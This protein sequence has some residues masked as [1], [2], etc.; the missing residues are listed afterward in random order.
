MAETVTPKSGGS[1]YMTSFFKVS[2]CLSH[3]SREIP[4]NLRENILEVK[5]NLNKN[6][7]S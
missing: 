4:M 7:I 5:L 3:F 1:S 2:S 6:V